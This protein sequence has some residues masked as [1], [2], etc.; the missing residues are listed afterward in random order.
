MEGKF[1]SQGAYI[2]V[3]YYIMSYYVIREM[4][5]FSTSCYVVCS[6]LDNIVLIDILQNTLNR[7][8]L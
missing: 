6:I 2:L 1:H 4:L 8:I 3:I 7:E 5:Y